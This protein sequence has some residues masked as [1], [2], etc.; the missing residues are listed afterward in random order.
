[1]SPIRR[2][3][4]KNTFPEATAEAEQDVPYA[5]TEGLAA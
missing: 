4:D 1:M 5:L 3:C 2:D